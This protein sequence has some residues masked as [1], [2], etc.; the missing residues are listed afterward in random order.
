MPRIKPLGGIDFAK[1][2]QGEICASRVRMQMDRKAVAKKTNCSYGTV[3]N[4]EMNPEKIPLGWLKRY[5]K[6]TGMK[7]EVIIEYLYER[8]E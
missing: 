7:P 5:I 3:R 4:Y 8:K 1:V 6:V 2:L